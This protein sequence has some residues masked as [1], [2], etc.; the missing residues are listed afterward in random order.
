MI[1]IERDKFL[2]WASAFHEYFILG[3]KVEKCEMRQQNQNA[4]QI[5]LTITIQ[6]VLPKKKKR[7]HGYN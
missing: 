5:Q 4:V 1:I 2:P 3:F 6:F 7:F